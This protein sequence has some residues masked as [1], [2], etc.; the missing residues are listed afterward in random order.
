GGAR[1]SRPDVHVVIVWSNALHAADRILADLR[2]F[3]LLASYR[4]EWRPERFDENVRRFYGYDLPERVD[5]AAGSGSAP[6]LLLVVRDPA[7]EY[8]VRERSWGLGPVN[9][10][11]YDGKQRWR[12]W[13]GGDFRVHA[14]VDRGEAARDV[15]LLLGRRLE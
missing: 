2:R 5:K 9:V 4:V 15:F 6:F 3:E 13:A 1:M 7:P 8:G 14:T 11:T 12:E 10:A